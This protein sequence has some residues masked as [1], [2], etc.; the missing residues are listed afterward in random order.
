MGYPFFLEQSII[1][2]ERTTV[3]WD[4]VVVVVVD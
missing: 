4:V 2:V 1:L 3:S